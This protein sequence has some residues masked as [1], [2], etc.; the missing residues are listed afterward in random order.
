M[1]RILLSAL[2]LS[3]VLG[4][5]TPQPS[6]SAYNSGVDAYRRQ[7]FAAARIFWSA[8][9]DEGE[10]LALNNL[11]YLLYYGKGGDAD[12]HR[13]V[14]YWKQAGKMG[15]S[16]AQWHLGVAFED[17]KAIPTNLIE[18]YAWYRCAVASAEVGK[19]GD[20]PEL[21]ETIARD[22]RHSLTEILQKLPASQFEAAEK[23]AKHY[24]TQYAKRADT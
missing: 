10:T 9:I 2:L 16:E 19:A 15:H 3:A 18:A 23:L 4:C 22:A 1:I 21:E 8:A 24:V 12:P 20:H 13:A 11:G 6:L 7:D 5:A 17:G 14:E